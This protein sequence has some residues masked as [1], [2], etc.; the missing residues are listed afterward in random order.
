[1]N[2][3]S[4]GDWMNGIVGKYVVG[5]LFIEMFNE[6]FRRGIV[7]KGGCGRKCVGGHPYMYGVVVLGGWR[8]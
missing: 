5:C 3:G 4:E 8:I 6:L 2:D 7:L 1:M